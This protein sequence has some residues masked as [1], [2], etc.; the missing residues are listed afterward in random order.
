[1]A[2]RVVILGGGT[3][4]TLTANR[5]G[6]RRNY[7][8]LREPIWSPCLNAFETGQSSNTFSIFKWNA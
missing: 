1:M 6:V 4:E 2:Q 7:D 3:G 5:A 8:N